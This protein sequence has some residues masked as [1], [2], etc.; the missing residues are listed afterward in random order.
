MKSK[1]A[2]SD[3]NLKSWPFYLFLHCCDFA[4]QQVFVSYMNCIAQSVICSGTFIKSILGLLHEVILEEIV[5]NVRVNI[6][7][8]KQT[9]NIF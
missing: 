4:S 9:S 8:R 5:G 7:I 2:L 6:N 1:I 3:K